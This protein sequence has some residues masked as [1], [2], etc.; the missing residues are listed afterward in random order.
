[1]VHFELIFVH[2]V[3]FRLRFS[4]A[5]MDVLLC[6]HHLYKDYPSSTELFT[7]FFINKGLD[8]L[9]RTSPVPS[10]SCVVEPI[11]VDW[12]ACPLNKAILHIRHM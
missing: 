3:K 1:M 10:S 9:C 8:Q 6:Q 2:G 11:Y 5:P 12:H 7:L 4:P